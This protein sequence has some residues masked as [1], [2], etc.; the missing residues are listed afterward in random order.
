MAKECESGREEN[1]EVR[2]NEDREVR[3][4]EDGEIS[5]EEFDA[6]HDG[7]SVLSEVDATKLQQFRDLEAAKAAVSL[8]SLSEMV[9]L[10]DL[11]DRLRGISDSASATELAIA[12]KAT[13]SLRA[14]LPNG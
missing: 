3:K 11:M 1:E 6:D 14:A 8:R 9:S 2:E 7:L 4:D 10:K 5:K 13:T 12:R